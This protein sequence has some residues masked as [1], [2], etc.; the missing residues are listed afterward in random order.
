LPYFPNP[1]GT[2]ASYS[3]VNYPYYIVDYPHKALA[4]LELLLMR[5]KSVF[6]KDLVDNMIKIKPIKIIMRKDK[7]GVTINPLISIA[8]PSLTN[9]AAD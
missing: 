8:K 1:A 6:T 9:S 3:I 4:S 2:T 7:I 5:E